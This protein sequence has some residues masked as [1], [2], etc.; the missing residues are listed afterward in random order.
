MTF[1]L[2]SSE[3]GVSSKESME[4]ISRIVDREMAWGWPSHSPVPHRPLPRKRAAKV[5]PFLPPRP[6]LPG[7]GGRG[8]GRAAL[9]R[10][11]S[12]FRVAERA[13]IPFAAPKD[14]A[15]HAMPLAAE[16]RERL[17]D[18]GR[19]TMAPKR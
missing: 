1:L 8:G 19:E 16:D 4:W 17:L 7:N 10:I 12:V 2:A 15:A 13:N 11:G 5:G 18:L 9:R 14:L 3:I 6:R